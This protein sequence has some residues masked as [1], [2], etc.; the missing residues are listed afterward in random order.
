MRR[1][2]SLLALAI[3]ACAPAPMSDKQAQAPGLAAPVPGDISIRITE[4]QNGQTVEVPVGRR[5]A[6]ALVGIPTAGYVWEATEVPAFVERLE[7][8]SGPTRREQNEPG[9]TGGS[10]WE[11][12]TFN[13]TAA[14][15]GELKLE[16]RRPWE[17]DQ[18]P[19]NVFIVTIAAR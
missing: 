13:A 2:I 10:H 18:P 8:A 14:G 4:N 5:F 16:Q 19:A 1:T 12:L 7:S 15:S 11:V 3:A 6:V 17:T 9:F